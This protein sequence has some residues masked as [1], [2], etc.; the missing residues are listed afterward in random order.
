MLKS[1]FKKGP[2]KPKI[3]PYLNGYEAWGPGDYV[4]DSALGPLSWVSVPELRGV[5]GGSYQEP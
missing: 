4:G 3:K 1:S 2:K 5:H